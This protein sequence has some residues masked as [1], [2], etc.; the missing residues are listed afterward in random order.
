MND[1]H[2]V[3]VRDAA[4][5]D[6]NS[7]SPVTKERIAALVRRQGADFVEFAVMAPVSGPGIEVPILAG[8]GK[9]D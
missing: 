9:A 4:Y 3:H 6:L 1:E 5:V 7:V 2:V 8:G